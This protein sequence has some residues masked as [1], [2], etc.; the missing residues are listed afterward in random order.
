MKIFD[1]FNLDVRKQNQSKFRKIKLLIC[2]VML[3]MS[4][5]IIGYRTISLASINKNNVSNKVYAEIENES[6]PKSLRGN[7]YDRNNKILATTINTL[8]LNVNP[9]EILNIDQTIA[10]LIK[11]FPQLE[12]K[13]LYKKLNSNK[14]FINLLK[15]ISPR[16][17]V[18]LLNAGIEGLK[19]ETKNKR[20]YPNNT[21]AA[22]ILGATDIDG[23]GIA[24]IEKK[25]D[26]QLQDGS[27]VTLSI[28]SGI[29]HITRTLLLDQIKKFKAEGGAGIIMNAKNG[30]VFSIVSLPDYNA[31]N[32]NS[33]LNYKL[34]NKA[35]KGIYELGS[36]LK[37]ITAAI[38]FDSNL[39]NENDVF[40]VSKPLKVS[41]RII[42]DF[43]PLNYAINIPEVIVH[44]SNI[45]S[46]KIAEKFG[47]ST[48]LKYLRSLGL[49]S[50][51]SLEIPELG[52][53]QVLI[54]K[55]VLSTMTI[56]YGH[57][58]SITPMHLASATATIVNS[59]AKV[60]PTLIKGKTEK[61]NE[62]IISNKTSLKMKSI[63]RLVVSNKYGTAKKAEAP[64]YLIG[65][66]TGTA[67]KIKPSGGYSKKE[68]IVAFTGAFPMND[69][70]F[71]ITIMIDNPKGQK[72]SFGHRT[73]GWVVAPIVK[74]LVTRVAPILGVNPQLESSSKFSNNLLNYKI[75]GKNHGANL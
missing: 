66:K 16:E 35:T 3:I 74:K 62:V 28:H 8:S 26:S 22:H 40:D 67:E 29:Q 42:N 71:I 53:P 65:G 41:S 13:V 58:I 1:F 7:I 4:F 51:L 30:E 48:Q 19:I 63:M 2:S 17:Y 55:K 9:Q 54:D 69:P 23:N 70:E 32:Y 44:S 39:I 5:T 20:I 31:N 56:S 12:E 75:R 25:F 45:G 15:E 46:A 38:A 50:I 73:A 59:G 47:S 21:L 49:L 27:N 52:K 57:G 64:G 14:K 61:K 34:F 72:F 11:I 18:S 36:T 68:N 24:G 6:I 37:L 33:I 60:N 43:H 10:K